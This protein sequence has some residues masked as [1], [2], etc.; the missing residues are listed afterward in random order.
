VVVVDVVVVDVEVVDVDVDDAAEMVEVA[1][2]TEVVAR[3]SPL[4]AL[5]AEQ[6]APS[7]A[8]ATTDAARFRFLR[9]RPRSRP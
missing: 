8:K 1:T 3:D 5:A 4:G 6:A 7:I 9:G 2:A